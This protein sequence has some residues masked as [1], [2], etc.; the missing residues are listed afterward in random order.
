MSETKCD[1][2]NIVVVDDNPNNLRVLG[3]MLQQAGYKVRPTA[4][5]ALAL[6]SIQKFPPDLV[7][8]DIRMPGMDGF[9]ICSHLKACEE[10]KEIPVIFISAMHETEG[11][12]AAFQ[13]GGVDYIAKPF[14]IEEVLARVDVHIR[15]HRM[16][17]NL[18]SIIAERVEELRKSYEELRHR[19]QQDK[20]TLKQTVEVIAKIIEKRDPYT[21]G[22]QRRVAE[23]AVAIA[24]QLGIPLDRIEGLRFAAM[25]H[26]IGKIHLP[27]EI[28]SRSGPLSP[29]E[30]SLV[31]THSEVGHE[32]LQDVEFPWPVA[33][34]ILQH[35]ERLDGSGYPF[36]LMADEIIEE[37]RILAVADVVEAMSSP[38]SYRTAL[39]VAAA[40]EELKKGCG[41]SYDASVV[42]AVVSL[43]EAGKIMLDKFEG[44]AAGE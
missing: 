5:G 40:L 12:V 27:A 34:L 19:Q 3:E 17:Q 35:H 28:L 14:Q 22:H 33:Q 10:L 26:D 31:K 29:T 39:G 6:R 13:A 20:A 2:G 4:S 37:A 1:S 7:L 11:K 23:L 36:G 8:L 32:I 18:E 41:T 38:R 25:I 30:Y 43:A 21:R 9:E 15:L 42:S 16:Q 44:A 24:N